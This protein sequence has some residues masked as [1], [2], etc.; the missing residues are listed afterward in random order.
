[1]SNNECP[2]W[3]LAPKMQRA[4]CRLT[5]HKLRRAVRCMAIRV[6]VSET[7]PFRPSKET[8]NTAANSEMGKYLHTLIVR[9]PVGIITFEMEDLF[10][11]S[12]QTKTHHD[13]FHLHL[14]IK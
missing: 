8:E 5:S 10:R 12:F 1:M 13:H 2:E 14:N 6:V 3:F 7:Y 4:Y 11:V 9:L